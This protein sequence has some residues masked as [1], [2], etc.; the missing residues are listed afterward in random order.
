MRVSIII[1][2]F[3]NLEYLKLII[4]SIKN[5][6]T[7]SHEIIVHINQGIDGSLDYVKKNHIKHTYSKEN[8]GLCSAVNTAALLSTTDYIM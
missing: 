8:I 3:N 1:P 4:K 7:Y 2:T 6:S 5:N